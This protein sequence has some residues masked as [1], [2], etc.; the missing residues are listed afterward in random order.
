L[1][2]LEKEYELFRRKNKL[3]ATYEV[4]IGHAWALDSPRGK[5]QQEHTFPLD[6]LRRRR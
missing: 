5:G 1:V 4:I 6:K 2:K 3:P